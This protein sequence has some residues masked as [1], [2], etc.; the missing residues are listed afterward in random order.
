MI[1]PRTERAQSLFYD[2]ELVLGTHRPTRLVEQFFH[3]TLG[4]PYPAILQAFER[5]G[6]A[7]PPASMRDVIERRIIKVDL[8]LRPF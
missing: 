3:E 6:P 8:L 5:S 7:N 4:I 2:K 1:F